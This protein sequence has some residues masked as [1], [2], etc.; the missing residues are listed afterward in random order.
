M[1]E[2]LANALVWLVLVLHISK[3]EV[4]KL[5]NMHAPQQGNKNIQESQFSYS[6]IMSKLH[7][8]SKIKKKK[9]ALKKQSVD[10]D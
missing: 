5:D 2:V 7:F 9:K 6:H 4:K 1:T 8:C 3:V 10:P